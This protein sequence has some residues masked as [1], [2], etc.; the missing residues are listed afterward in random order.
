MTLPPDFGVYLSESN[1]EPGG[2]SLGFTKSKGSARMP[3]ES[4]KDYRCN[5][6]AVRVSQ[7]TRYVGH[8]VAT[9]LKPTMAVLQVA[10]AKIG[11]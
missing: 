11:V 4:F 8:G 1:W 6:G 7:S 2:P 9:P 10:P 5:Q 3:P